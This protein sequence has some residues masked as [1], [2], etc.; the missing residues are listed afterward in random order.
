MELKGCSLRERRPQRGFP[1]RLQ[2][3]R[4]L[5]TACAELKIDRL[6][7]GERMQWERKSRLGRP[8]NKSVQRSRGLFSRVAA[9]GT[10]HTA[11][12]PTWWL[13][14]SSS[15]VVYLFQHMST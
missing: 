13:T 1:S 4:L 10:V 11:M 15:V 2:K 6:Y 9:T 8:H 3:L 12:P 5:H 7:S 14:H